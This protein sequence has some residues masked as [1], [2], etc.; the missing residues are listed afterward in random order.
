MN[1]RERMNHIKKHSLDRNIVL[2]DCDA[3]L[4][5]LDVFEAVV[6]EPR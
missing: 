1:M 3:V 6:T 5:Y 2:E 4:K